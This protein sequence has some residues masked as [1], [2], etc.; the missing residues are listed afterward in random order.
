MINLAAF[1][2]QQKSLDDCLHELTDSMA[3]ILEVENCSIMLFRRDDEDGE[4]RLRLRAVHGGLLPD[5]H[6][7][8]VEINVG[9]V[10]RVAASGE[11]LLIE[12]ILCSEF[13]SPDCFPNSTGNSFISV[14]ILVSGK[15]VGVINVSDPVDGRTLTRSDM[16]LT[17]LLALLVGRS[18]HVSQLQNLLSSRYAQI[19]LL[20]ESHEPTTRNL[21]TGRGNTEQLVKLFAKTF[22][23]EMTKA[24]FGRDHII[25]AATEIIS[26]LSDSLNR[27]SRRCRRSKTGLE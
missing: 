19:A 8:A 10:G 24:G 22:Y 9:I 18:L 20:K 14:P 4:F 17:T 16:E 6:M 25:E 21:I 15:V 2:E 1:L 12:D 11:P 3:T 27:H 7:E 23:R 26:L 5:L 13:S